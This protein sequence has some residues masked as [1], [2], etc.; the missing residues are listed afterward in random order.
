[1]NKSIY[2]YENVCLY[3]YICIYI[4]QYLCIIK[5]FSTFERFIICGIPRARTNH[6]HFVFN[7]ILLQPKLND[8]KS[9]RSYIPYTH[10]GGICTYRLKNTKTQWL[11]NRTHTL[12]IHNHQ[13]A[14]EK[15][16]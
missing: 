14:L 3:L 8:K 15:K 2:I 10:K 6:K 4:P 11:Q 7:I 1:M 16:F 12:T 9:I 5:V 13:S